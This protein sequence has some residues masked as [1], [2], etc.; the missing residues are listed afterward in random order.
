MIEV[1]GTI[2]KAL[3]EIIILIGLLIS[4]LEVPAELPMGAEVLEPPVEVNRQ[5]I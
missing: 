4:G 3:E 5:L 2:I 1:L